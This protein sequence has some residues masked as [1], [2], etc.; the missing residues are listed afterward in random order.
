MIRNSRGSIL[1]IAKFIMLSKNPMIIIW[2]LKPNR[3]ETVRCGV[4]TQMAAARHTNE[5]MTEQRSTI[6][7][8]G[9]DC[10]FPIVRKLRVSPSRAAGLNSIEVACGGISICEYLAL[11]LV[12][13][14]ITPRSS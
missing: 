13:K 10:G 2:P 9:F 7:N 4:T 6:S 3:Q 11:A 12:K 8:V 5:P 1:F 14:G